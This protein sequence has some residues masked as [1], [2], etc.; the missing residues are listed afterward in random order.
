MKSKNAVSI[1]L[2]T[3]LLVLFTGRSAVSQVSSQIEYIIDRSQA[4]NAFWVVQVRDSSGNVLEDLNGD[5]LIRP[6]S[7]L[8]LVSSGAFLDN[9]GSDYTFKT[10]IYGRGEQ[11]GDRW[12]GD[13]IIKGSGDPSIG[14]EFNNNDPLFLFEKWYQILD[15]LGIKQIDGNIIAYDGLFDDVPYPRGWEWD[16]LTYYYAPEINALSFNSNVVNLEVRADGEIGSTP[17]I[18]W[19]PFNTPYVDFVNEQVITP[20]GTRYNESYRRILGTN[21][22]VLRST[23]PRGYYE[24]EPLSVMAPSL[25]F[26][27]TFSRYLEEAGIRFSGQ[28][29]TDS[30]YYA[31]NEEGLKLFD[32]HTS[33]SVGSMVQWLNRESDN[34][35]TEMLTKMLSVEKFGIQGSTELGIGVIKEFM[36]STGFDTL[37]V[38][39]RDASGMAPSTL[40]NGSDL[41]RYLV[42]I[43]DKPWFN[44]LYESLS[45]GGING[46][47][48]HRFRN[49]SVNG[50]FY[51][52]S[53]FV[54]GV[55]SLSGYLQTK[56]NNRIAVTI[57]TNNYTVRTAHIDWVHERILEYL[58]N[59]F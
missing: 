47:L 15:S 26:I 33:V 58:Y 37:S 14:G 36:H 11:E 8:K 3:A 52:K 16:D 2:F 7:N 6:A 53:G 50:N 17:S 4:G 19:F 42:N 44:E 35:Y 29:L 9:L 40:V 39:L 20:S 46:T 23:L 13:L 10:S 49:S 45:I 31:W 41:N 38:N 57:V 59:G 43:Q 48:G 54:S 12:R 28:L 55:R 51:G 25:Y 34:F 1:I 21:T 24:T 27:D 30:D 5:K 56:S 32:T 18:Q 22:I